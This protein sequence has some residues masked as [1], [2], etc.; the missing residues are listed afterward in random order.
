M[1]TWSRLDDRSIEQYNIIIIATIDVRT[2][3]RVFIDAFPVY[4][5]VL[6]SRIEWI[7]VTPA[8]GPQFGG[9]RATI[10]Y[11]FTSHS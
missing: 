9:S 6:N 7:F 5:I 2:S 10:I 8:Q 3:I 11:Q 4:L 1:C